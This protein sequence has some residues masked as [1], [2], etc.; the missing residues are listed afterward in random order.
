MTAMYSIGRRLGRFCFGTFGKLEVMG[1][2]SVPP[3]APLIVIA[4]HVSFNDPPVLVAAMDRDLSFIGKR[5]LFRDP[6]SSFFMRGFQVY[7]L[8]RSG[9]GVDG[10]R[11][12]LSLLAQDRA[13]VIFPEGRRSPDHALIPGQPGAAYVALKAQ[14]SILPV[15][16]TG[17][18]K[19]PS[20]RM[21]LPLC[22]LRVNIG[23]PF[24]L[25][26]IDGAPNRQVLK[27]LTDMMMQRIAALLP[28]EYRGAYSARKAA[29]KK[30]GPNATGIQVWNLPERQ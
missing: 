3:F 21:P 9:S 10:V 26:S 6:V 14:A 15:G 25:P 19:F 7:P 2:E 12:A 27:N 5:E 4:N 8:D 22:R 28:E 20:W 23:Q 16:I 18:E 24:S 30:E 29:P 11:L 17:G 1:R 13:V